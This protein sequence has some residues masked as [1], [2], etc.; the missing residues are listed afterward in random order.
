M[1]KTTTA[2][3][4]EARFGVWRALL[5]RPPSPG[6]WRA[7][8]REGRRELAADPARFTDAWLPY[9]E[10]ILARWPDALRCADDWLRDLMLDDPALPLGRLVR[11][12]SAVTVE[13][14]VA[15]R[16]RLPWVQVHTFAPN[17]PLSVESL[18]HLG[19]ALVGVRALRLPGEEAVAARIP[20]WIAAHPE[21]F[22]RLE[23]LDLRGCGITGAGV[24][25]LARSPHLSALRTLQ[26]GTYGSVW[27]KEPNLIGDVGA[28][29]LATSPHLS[30]LERLDLTGCRLTASEV[31]AL[32]HSP[33]LSGLR[34]LLLCTQHHAVGPDNLVG[35]G[36][37]ALEALASSPHLTRLE[38][39][40]LRYGP[41]TAQGFADLLAEAPFAHSL[42]AIKLSGN[43]DG[44]GVLMALAES[45]ARLPALEE[46]YMS[47]ANLQG[48]DA[49]A[50]LADSALGPQLKHLEL[51]GAGEAVCEAFV[52][53]GR[54]PNLDALVLTY[55][56]LSDRTLGAILAAM[57]QTRLKIDSDRRRE[58]VHARHGDT[59]RMTHSS[60]IR[61]TLSVYDELGWTPTPR[62]VVISA[63]GITREELATW[64]QQASHLSRLEHLVFRHVNLSDAHLR[65]LASCPNLGALRVLE[66]WALHQSVSVRGLGALCQSEH[67]S[68]LSALVV[69]GPTF[70]PAQ[71]QALREAAPFAV[72]LD[73]TS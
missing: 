36:D 47:Y 50:M 54:L 24:T 65:V 49:L 29:A 11:G 61:Y 12:V 56:R 33:H 31:R 58:V 4:A 35:L 43:P 3:T 15:I 6:T 68:G 66:V 39:L 42:R 30:A 9:A 44:D 69:R 2:M 18:D 72:H 8:C 71:A 26:L 16:E 67:L 27:P 14:V 63:W 62:S 13:Q 19:D 45:A 10:A 64:T 34:E 60:T 40:G 28:E 7:L 57:P 25:A 51:K 46:I 52:Q 21:V 53:P 55:A 38:R 37:D 70:T 22:D 23:L 73:V 59:V 32:A 1:S 17:R 41:F 20:P 48:A 5:Q